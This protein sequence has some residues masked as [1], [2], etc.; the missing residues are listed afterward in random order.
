MGVYKRGQ[1]WYYE[2][3][4]AG[5]RIKESARTTRKWVAVEAERNRRLELEKALSGVSQSNREERIRSVSDACREYLEHYA[6][7][8]RPKSVLFAKNSLAHVVRILGTTLLPDLTETVIRRYMRSRV[9]EGV[10]GRSVNAELGELSRAIGQPWRVLW[11][12]VRKMEERKDVGRALSPEEEARLLTEASK[13][14]SVLLPTFVRIALCTGMRCGEILSLTWGQ[15]EFT[16]RI[17]FVGT[18]KTTAGTGRAIPMNSELFATLTAHAAWFTERFGEADATHFVFP[19]GIR[20]PNDPTRPATTLKRA[21]E[22]LRDRAGVSCRLHDLRHT[23]CTKLAEAGVPESTM[24]AIMGHMSRQMLDR[25]SHIR[26]AAKRDAVEAM[27][28][29]PKAP[30]SDGVPPKST[31]LPES[32]SIQ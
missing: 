18:S 27:T 19:F 6:L 7:N 8:H 12:K 32:A 11:P 5:K 17:V 3:I 28:T 4:F 26:M 25:Y 23:A 15:V 31:P 14:A 30:I 1:N 16:S 10:S 2:F 22:N 24:L 20:I 29:R 13:S 9:N 21:W